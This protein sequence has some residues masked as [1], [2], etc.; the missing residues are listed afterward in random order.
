MCFAQL[1][2]LP[3]VFGPQLEPPQAAALNLSE[4]LLAGLMPSI[5]ASPNGHDPLI[6]QHA[7]FVLHAGEQLVLEG[8]CP[9]SVSVLCR[10]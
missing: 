2:T 4:P 5:G 10:R 6:P 8:I 9:H 1:A 7:S 3:M